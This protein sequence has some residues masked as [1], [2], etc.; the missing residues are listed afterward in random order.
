[1][2]KHA[3]TCQWRINAKP[4]TKGD[5]DGKWIVSDFFSQHSCRDCESK[6]K[7]NYNSKTINGACKAVS[8]FI[9][10]EKRLGS[11]KQLMDM[12]RESDGIHLTKSHAYKIVQTKSQNSVPVH[13]GQYLLL[14]S[15]F[16]FLCAKDE[17][18]TF[19]LETQSCTWNPLLHQFKRCYVYFSYVKEFW[20][21]NGCTP[22]FAVDGTFT[23]S[24]IIKHTVETQ[25]YLYTTFLIIV[26]TYD[27]MIK[28]SE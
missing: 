3:S 13:I 19:V 22:L 21:R 1:M 7:R 20:A 28:D 23:T 4:F 27:G 15:Y 24:G 10:S 26:Q 14:E 2:E 6:R 25:V 18:G 5:P 11:T 8:T 16:E 17:N 12:T 9:P